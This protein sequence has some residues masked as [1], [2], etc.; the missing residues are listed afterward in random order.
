MKEISAAEVQERLERGEALHVIDVRE[1]DEV[2][3]GII[4]GAVHI[5]LGEI[6]ERKD[7]LTKDKA[8]ILVCRSG[9]RSGRA[10]EYLATEGYDVTNMVGG[11]LDWEGAT[12]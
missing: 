1:D 2:A 7:E 8:Y 11:M 12:K 5:A 9:G 10:C 6:P 4:P 3:A